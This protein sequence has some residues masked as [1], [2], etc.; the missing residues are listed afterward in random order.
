MT[1]DICGTECYRQR[2]RPGEGWKS[3]HEKCET[4]KPIAHERRYKRGSNGLIPMSYVPRNFDP[5]TP[6]IGVG[7]CER[8]T[9]FD[10]AMGQAV[11][12]A[13]G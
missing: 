12:R 3:R 8:S 1:C 5:R 6:G 9:A 10:P 13:K 11:K 4:Q 7:T 2:F